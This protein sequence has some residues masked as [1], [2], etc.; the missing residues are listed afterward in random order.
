METY[1]ANVDMGGLTYPMFRKAWRRTKHGLDASFALPDIPA[2][3]AHTVGGS[4]GSI[5]PMSD[6]NILAAKKLIWERNPERK[7]KAVSLKEISD[8]IVKEIMPKFKA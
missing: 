1:G 4:V 8:V 2:P 7:G 3:G 5:D 6:A